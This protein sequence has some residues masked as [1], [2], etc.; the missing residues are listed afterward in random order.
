MAGQALPGGQ[1]T[2][3]NINSLAAQGIQGAGMGAVAGMGYSPQQVGVAGTSATVNQMGLSPTVTAGQLSNTSLD[4]YMNPYTTSVIDAQ[5]AD[6][7]RGAN[8]GLDQLGAQAQAARSFGGSRHGIAMSEMGRGVAEMMG[9]QAAG[10]RQANYAQAQQAAQQDIQANMQGQMANQAGGQFDIRTEMQRQMANQ[11][12]GQQDIQNQL[13]ASLAN[14]S[15][16]L[17]GQQQ[18]LG[19]ASQLGNISNLGFGMGQTVNQNLATQGAMQ[20][21][22]QQAVF[23][24]SQQKYGQYTGHPAQ[25]LSYL[26]AALGVAP[27]GENTQT[28]SKQP[29]LFDY[30]TLGASGYTGGN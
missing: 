17:Q 19:A 7:L 27:Q 29:G 15:A 26:N 24:A 14:Q 13:Q 21:A 12:A 9:Q 5:Q 20:Q 2:P 8:I 18:R 22:L 10:L 6:I 11:G 25:G 28:L 23:D 16:G 1:T 4:P 3:P 30:L